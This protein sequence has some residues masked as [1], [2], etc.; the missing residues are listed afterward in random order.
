LWWL[1]LDRP[2]SPLPFH[3]NS[4]GMNGG[5]M[6]LGSGTAGGGRGGLNPFDP[7]DPY[8]PSPYSPFLLQLEDGN[9]EPGNWQAQLCFS[10]SAL[11]F[12][13]TKNL[14]TNFLFYQKKG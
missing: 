10:V 4:A 1:V 8:S 14:S 12:H 9:P 13:I 7:F 2:S 6:G 3:P 11:T 5:K